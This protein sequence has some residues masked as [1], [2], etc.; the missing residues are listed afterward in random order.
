LR[1]RLLLAVTALGL[2]LALQA[3]AAPSPDDPWEHANRRFFASHNGLD[4]RFL[5]PIARLYHALTPGVI[6]V[7]IHNVI[8]NL[9]EPVVIANDI[10]QA[11][12]RQASHDTARLAANSTLGVLGLADVATD[13]GLPHH[14]NDFGVTLGRWGFK[15][16]PYLFLPLVGP[17]T[18]RDML[19]KGVD[20]VMN[21]LNFMRFPGRLTLETSTTVVGGLDTRIRSQS[22][23]DALLGDAADPYATMRSVYLQSR[24]AQIRGEDTSPALAPLEDI[25]PETPPPAATPQPTPAPAPQSAAPQTPDGAKALA[26]TSATGDPD[27]PIA[28][29][30]PWDIDG[31]AFRLAQQGA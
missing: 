16:G 22:D 19:G 5:L 1:P 11:R 4:Q 14:D 31:T 29:A 20:A 18:F 17:S 6:G 12:L 8:T 7:A 15:P 2:S 26:E 10:L 9:S 13:A 24:E 23:L 21:P 28:T 30:R 25:T 3:A 27:A